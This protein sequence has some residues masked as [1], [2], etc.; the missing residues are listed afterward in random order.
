MRLALA[1]LFGI[2]EVSMFAA[3]GDAC[4]GARLKPICHLDEVPRCSC[5]RPENHSATVCT[6]VCEAKR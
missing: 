1:I 4:P 6:W 3:S 5:F 2:V